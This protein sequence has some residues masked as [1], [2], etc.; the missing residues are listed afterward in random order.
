MVL[1][2]AASGDCGLDA[3]LGEQ[4]ADGEPAQF[5]PR[6]PV[7]MGKQPVDVEGLA[8]QRQ[9]HARPFAQRHGRPVPDQ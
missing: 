6:D 3:Q 7:A 4:L 5:G 1:D 8:A 2:R 9:E